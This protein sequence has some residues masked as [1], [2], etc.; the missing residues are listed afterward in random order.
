MTA[1]EFAAA[2]EDTLDNLDSDLDLLA[3]ELKRTRSFDAAG[4]L[5]RDEGLIV[6]MKDGSEFQ[7]TVLQSR[8]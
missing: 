8:R 5:T 4:L 7:V 3:L 1:E 6:T 2:L